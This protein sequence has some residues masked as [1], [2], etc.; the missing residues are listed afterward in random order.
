MR[1]DAATL[2]GPGQYQPDV[3]LEF[4]DNKRNEFMLESAVFM[5]KSARKIDK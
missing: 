3:S 1:P 5:K 2:P 4:F